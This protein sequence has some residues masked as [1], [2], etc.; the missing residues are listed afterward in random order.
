M[1]QRNTPVSGHLSVTRSGTLWQSVA[2][3]PHKR[4]TCSGRTV[5]EL[6]RARF[7]LRNGARLERI[8][9]S[10]DIS[11]DGLRRAAGLTVN[12]VYRRTSPR[13]AYDAFTGMQHVRTS[14]QVTRLAG[15]VSWLFSCYPETRSDHHAAR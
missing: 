5:P 4:C 6:G 10:S 15:Q 1:H 7:H 13:R 9:W 2:S 8:K 11:G 3:T 12:Y 14:R